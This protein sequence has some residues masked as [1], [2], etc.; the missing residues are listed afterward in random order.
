MN[1]HPDSTQEFDFG[2]HK[3]HAIQEY[4]KVLPLYEEYVTAIKHVLS[5]AFKSRHINILSIEAR[6]KEVDSFGDKASRP[7]P[8]DPS[9]PCYP[10]PLSD[11]T[12]KAGIRIIV[13]LPRTLDMVDDV[14]Q[15][16]FE[17]IEKTDTALILIEQEKFGYASI[18]YLVRFKENRTNLLEYSR[19]KNLVAEIQMR[20]ILQHA[21]AEIEHDIQYKAIDTIPHTIRRR[22]MSLSGILEIADREFQAIQDDDERLK[23]AARESLQE[24]KLK[25]VEITSNALKTYLDKKLEPDRRMTSFSYRWTAK[26]LRNL[27]F[28]NFEQIEECVRNFNDDELSRIAWGTRQGQLNRF[29]YLLLAGMG[30][31]Y[32]RFHPL[33][34]SDWFVKDFKRILSKFNIAGI[35]V[36]SYLPPR[37]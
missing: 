34:N 2:N 37:E 25:Q 7:S 15:S 29:E 27:G 17:V 28:S 36:G 5:E 10:N 3:L 21:W 22:F 26:V 24:G 6:A 35:A 1:G 19:F 32:L 8:D 16:Q 23:L 20:T 33:K 31:N 18:H 9:K 12:D 4:Q 13:F 14:I 11:I 30:E